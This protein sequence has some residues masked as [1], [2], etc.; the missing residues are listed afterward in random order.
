[1]DVTTLLVSHDIN[2]L[3]QVTDRVIFLAHGHSAIG[4]PA[5]VIN[6]ETLSRLYGLP[7]EVA[8][9]MDRFFVVGAEL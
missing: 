9:V 7:V 6:S 1:M 8:K 3:L 4:G 5:E 2:P